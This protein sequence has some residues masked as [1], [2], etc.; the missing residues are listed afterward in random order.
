M[1]LPLNALK[2]ELAVL[3]SSGAALEFPD[4]GSVAVWLELPPPRKDGNMLLLLPPL[5]WDYVGPHTS[6]LDD[7]LK[8]RS[9]TRPL[10]GQESAQDLRAYG[11][12]SK[13]CR[14]LKTYKYPTSSPAARAN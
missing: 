9:F 7:A 11:E 10:N 5:G 3:D 1:P 8:L 14:Y 4:L 6:A 2:E 13:N 12:V